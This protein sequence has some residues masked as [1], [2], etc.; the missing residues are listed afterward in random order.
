MNIFEELRA[1]HDIQRKLMRRA[2]DTSGASAERTAAWTA[3]KAALADHAAAEE[4][5]F[6]APL[7]QHDLTVEH[8]RHSVAEHKDLDD[9]VEAVDA[10]DSAS[11]VWLHH[12]KELA[13]RLEHHLVEEER[14]VFPLAGRA[15]SDSDK[16]SLGRDYRDEMGPAVAA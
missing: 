6:Y 8:A 5:Y 3:L 7:F 10:A 2:L 11:S 4:R 15:L 9:L 16:R 12:L 14:E 13:H 1:D